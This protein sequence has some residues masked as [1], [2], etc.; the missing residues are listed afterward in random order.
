MRTRDR[1]IIRSGLSKQQTRQSLARFTLFESL[2]QV[3]LL[4]SG[5][6]TM[7][8][9][10]FVLSLGVSKEQV[11]YFSTLA[12]AACIVPLLLLPAV[13][14]LG[15]RRS[16]LLKML[17]A[18]P[19]LMI[20]AIGAVPWLPPGWRLLAVGAAVFLAASFLNITTPFTGEWIATI[21]PAEV[22][23]RYLGRKLR[24]WAAGTMAGVLLSGAAL[25]ILGKTNTLGLAGALVFG[26]LMGLLS[27]AAIGGMSMPVVSAG[28]QVQYRDFL[29]ALRTK[30]FRRVLATFLLYNVPFYFGCPYYQA[31]YQETLH[32]P[33]MWIAALL[34]GYNLSKALTASWAGRLIDR[35]GPRRPLMWFGGSYVAFFLCYPL[36]MPG[37]YWILVPAWVMVGVVESIFAVSLL[38]SLYAAVPRTPARPAYFLLYSLAQLSMFGLGSAV[39]AP[40]L[41]AIKDVRI[42]LGPFVFT[43]MHLLYAVVT[44]LMI[45]ALFAAMLLPKSLR[46]ENAGSDAQPDS[47]QENSPSSPPD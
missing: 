16:L 41:T 19:L 28:T 34:V 15:N 13:T 39:A 25:Q 5:G 45:P 9:V 31:F 11:G 38:G 17:A 23:G 1:D 4:L 43:N 44:V 2:R 22:R 12:S 27:V 33:A 3:Y 20:V 7:I 36:A 14:R 40:I 46:G 18:E 21:I 29:T 42:V 32:M 47:G 30:S 8:F 26:G 10:A 37:W 35:Y 24:F 6:N